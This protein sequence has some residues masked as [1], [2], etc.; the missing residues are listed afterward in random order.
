[1]CKGESRFLEAS[2]RKHIA[3]LLCKIHEIDTCRL[4]SLDNGWK[5]IT[6]WHEFPQKYLSHLQ[7]RQDHDLL[8]TQQCSILYQINETFGFVF[9]NRHLR[10]NL[11]VFID[12]NNIFIVVKDFIFFKVLDVFLLGQEIIPNFNN[13]IIVIY[14]TFT[15]HKHSTPESANQ[16]GIFDSTK[17]KSVYLII[18]NFWN[19]NEVVVFVLLL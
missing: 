10:L 4:V 11:F 9:W 6:I 2:L 13:I 8:A 12:L 7:E 5:V 18:F 14:M 19:L 15:I 1:M 3:I 17:V 16:F